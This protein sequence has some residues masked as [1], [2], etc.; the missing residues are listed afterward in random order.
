VR[1]AK[2]EWLKEAKGIWAWRNNL[3]VKNAWRQA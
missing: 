1:K 3:A 2:E